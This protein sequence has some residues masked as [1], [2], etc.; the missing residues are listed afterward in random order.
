MTT[1]KPSWLQEL[2]KQ[3]CLCVSCDDCRGSGVLRVG[4]DGLP[5]VD[6]LSELINCPSCSNGLA[7]VCDRCQEL[8]D[9]DE[10]NWE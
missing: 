9:Y 8:D 1:Q 6:D 5:A 4:F 10:E 2:E 7:E 3:P